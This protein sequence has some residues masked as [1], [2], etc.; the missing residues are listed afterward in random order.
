MFLKFLLNDR[1]VFTVICPFL[2]ALRA[3]CFLLNRSV[4]V[5]GVL[6][7]RGRYIQLPSG[8]SDLDPRDIPKRCVYFVQNAAS[9]SEGDVQVQ[10]PLSTLHNSLRIAWSLTGLRF[11]V[12]FVW[13]Y[14]RCCRR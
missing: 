5:P 12:G 1:A 14:H 7:E 8:L 4:W 6:S 9:P 10:N 2:S 11:R 3:S 13:W